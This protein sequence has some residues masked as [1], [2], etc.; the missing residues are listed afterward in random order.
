MLT[1]QSFPPRA[2]P[3]LTDL[4]FEVISEVVSHIDGQTALALARVARKLTQPSEAA[5]WRHLNLSLNPNFG[6]YPLVRPITDHPIESEP[7]EA[8]WWWWARQVGVG[9]KEQEAAIVSKV[10][11]VIR[12]GN[13]GRWQFVREISVVLRPTI[14][15]QLRGILAL[16]HNLEKLKI[17]VP[18]RPFYEH[19]LD[20]GQLEDL[21]GKSL[22]VLF[23]KSLPS[24]PHLTHLHLGKRSLRYAETIILLCNASPNLTH[25]D[26]D[27]D[28]EFP[29]PWAQKIPSFPLR[30]RS[31]KITDLRLRFRNHEEE[32]DDDYTPECE[33]CPIVMKL[34][35]SVPYVERLSITYNESTPSART[36]YNEV[37]PQISQYHNLEELHWGGK[38]RLLLEAFASLCEQDEEDEAEPEIGFESLRKLFL[39][40]QMG[41]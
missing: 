17:T 21:H 4:P 28:Q 20:D 23:L 38:T 22:D 12:R 16:T 35:R 37:I 10:E 3:T 41:I 7:E 32:A 19:E 6:L 29:V 5:I 40:S 9:E 18:P 31:T 15:K 8:N 27:L 14:T 30:M 13:E 39:G 1:P 24:F 33:A 2:R 26:V 36:V 34:L 11:G 25:L